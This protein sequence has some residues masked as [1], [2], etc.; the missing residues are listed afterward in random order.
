MRMSHTALVSELFR[1]SS[2]LRLDVPLVEATGVWVT[3]VA[4]LPRNRFDWLL[5]GE[6]L[7]PA[8]LP[9]HPPLLF[10]FTLAALV[11]FSSS[12]YFE[13]AEK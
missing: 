7:P 5:V 3:V 4:F 12:E 2:T 1:C 10:A 8:P 6:L 11:A 9:L 13:L